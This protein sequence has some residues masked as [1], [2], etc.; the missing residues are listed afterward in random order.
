M[1]LSRLLFFTAFVLF[2]VALIL[3]L[4]EGGRTDVWLF[5]G[6]SALALGHAVPDTRIG[7]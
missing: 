4:T 2:L 5:G 6:L 3:T 7:T 1:T